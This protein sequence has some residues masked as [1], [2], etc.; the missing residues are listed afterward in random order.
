MMI[1]HVVFFITLNP[2]SAWCNLSNDSSLQ[3]IAQF[4][5]FLILLCH[6]EPLGHL[7]MVDTFRIRYLCLLYT[8][9]FGPPSTDEMIK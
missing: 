6:A 7:R 9:T 1:D 4:K 2:I 8:L 3:P 5:L